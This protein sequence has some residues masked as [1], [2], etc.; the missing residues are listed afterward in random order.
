MVRGFS[1]L[2]VSAAAPAVVMFNLPW[3]RA[4]AFFAASTAVR[5]RPDSL[6]IVFP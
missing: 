6:K 4:C 2:E 5:F 3:H 1:D